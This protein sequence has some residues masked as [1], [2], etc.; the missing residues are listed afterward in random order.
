MLNEKLN[1]LIAESMK[2]KN[3]AKTITLR[4]IKSEF[5][6]KEK[7]G[8][9]ITETVEAS[10]LFKMIQQREDAITEFKKANR[11]D[12]VEKE[13]IELNIIKEFAPKQATDEEIINETEK[14]INSMG[15]TVTMK[16]MRTILS[17]VQKTYPTANGKIISEVVKRYV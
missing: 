10:I 3:T 5:V 1:T 14:V 12:L 13:Q 15:G 9:T 8:V 6:K 7:E 2:E 16:D 17:E 4:G 11:M